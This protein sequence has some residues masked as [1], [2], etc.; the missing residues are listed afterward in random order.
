ME[1]Y[2]APTCPKCGSHDIDLETRGTL[3][4]LQCGHGW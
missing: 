4:C 3:K 1:K 2:G